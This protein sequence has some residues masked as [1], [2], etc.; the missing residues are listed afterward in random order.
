MK[1]RMIYDHGVRMTEK[2]DIKRY[3][4]GGRGKFTLKST[5]SDK[6]IKYKVSK[7]KK[8]DD[9]LFISVYSNRYY[10]FIGV[11]NIIHSTYTHSKKSKI[12]FDDDGVR[13]IVWLMEQFRGTNEFPIGMEFYHMG[14]CCCCGRT[15]EVTDNIQLGIGPICFKNYGNKRMKKI[16]KLKKLIEHTR[17]FQSKE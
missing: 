14:I 1:M 2:N 7:C 4:F 11:M 5:K 10:E 9:I 17:K 13:G 12:P 6:I 15:L 8:N 3:V 16:F